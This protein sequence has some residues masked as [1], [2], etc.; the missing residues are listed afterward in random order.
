VEWRRL[1]VAGADRLLGRGVLYGA[2][3]LSLYLPKACV[4]SAHGAFDGSA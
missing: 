2:L 1:E 4:D 3:V